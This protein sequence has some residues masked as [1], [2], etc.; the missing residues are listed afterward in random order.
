M[1]FPPEVREQALV[2][3]A[4]HCCVCHR[5]KG[6]KVEV[7]HIVPESK[8]GTDD[9]DNA[10][11]LC[12][13]CHTDA[14]HYNPGHPRGTKFSPAELRRA[15]EAWHEIVQRNAIEP[16]SE[17]DVLYCR[18]LVCKSFEAFREVTTGDFS[19]LP[20]E[21]PLFVPNE[22]HQF[23][24]NLVANHPSSYRHEQEWG[25]TFENRE[26]YSR[27][28]PDVRVVE[29]SITDL[30]PYFEAIRR[31]SIEELRQKLA[32]NDVVTRLLVEGGVPAGEISLVLAYDEVCGEA[33]FQ[34]IYRIRPLW[35]LYLAVTNLRPNIVTLRTMLCEGERPPGLGYRSLTQR[36]E[37]LTSEEPFSA[38]GVPSGATVAVP[39]AT[40][41]GPLEDVQFLEASSASREL[42]VGLV[43]TLSHCDLSSAYLD[44]AMISPALWPRS[45]RLEDAGTIR[46][47]LLHEFELS[48]VYMIDRS[49][50]VGSCPH[51]FFLDP[52][53]RSPRYAGELF[54]R[55]PGAN[56]MHTIRVPFGVSTI[57]IAEL[58]PERTV[59]EQ[60]SVNG[61]EC[62]TSVVLEQ[63]QSLM[64]E[65]ESD[66]VVDI[67]GMYKAILTA[68]RQPLY[69]NRLIRQYITADGLLGY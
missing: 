1:P 41:L 56:Q 17:A 45:L 21:R 47:Q 22:V 30:Y 34:E 42:Q 2:A 28:H 66:D 37:S 52:M 12:F 36:L 67:I 27:A 23:H 19:K 55:Q 26:A 46:Q 43:Q 38:A 8:G 61:R 50:L 58:E 64:I 62:Y 10:I 54:S 6:V 18:Y 20:L 29:R 15:R 40:L 33:R 31:P 24:K 4:R 63:G 69:R 32:P 44:T 25:D 51:L 48:R 13:D 60:I 57:V 9:I 53:R 39:L 5:Y 16:P 3:A 35:A 65:V 59:I 49:W 68:P 11:A 7:H 14:G